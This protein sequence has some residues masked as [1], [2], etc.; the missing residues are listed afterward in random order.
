MAIGFSNVL[1]V[2]ALSYAG[3]FLAFA[4]SLRGVAGEAG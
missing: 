2:A 3:G 4:P 1:L